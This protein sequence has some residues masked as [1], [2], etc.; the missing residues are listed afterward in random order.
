[1]TRTLA[2]VAVSLGIVALLFVASFSSEPPAVITD[3]GHVVK[4]YKQLT[5]KQRRRYE[6]EEL[7]ECRKRDQAAAK[8]AEENEQLKIEIA[9]REAEL[10]SLQRTNW[11]WDLIDKIL[12]HSTEIAGLWIAY[13][14]F[15]RVKAS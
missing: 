11:L 5:K 3:D 2:E 13:L 8:T 15:A 12:S 4:N 9:G 14:T 6:L 10:K 1:M 7:I